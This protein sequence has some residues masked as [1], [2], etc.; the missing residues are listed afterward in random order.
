MSEKWR[1]V[2]GYEIY[3]GKGR[4]VADLTDAL[5]W[6]MTPAEV[7]ANAERIVDAVNNHKPLVK[8][9]KDFLRDMDDMDVACCQCEHMQLDGD[10]LCAFCTLEALLAEIKKDTP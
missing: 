9:A 1:A 2:D 3:D 8:A 10:E 5:K 7:E 4:F 6:G